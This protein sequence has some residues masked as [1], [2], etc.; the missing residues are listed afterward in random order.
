MGAVARASSRHV[1]PSG[2]PSTTRLLPVT[3][4]APVTVLEQAA[5]LLPQAS[6]FGIYGATESLPITVIDSKEILEETRFLSAKG[7]GVCIGK[8]VEGVSDRMIITTYMARSWV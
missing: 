3:A 8:R 4:P 5:K 7:A 6:I 1:R 2:I